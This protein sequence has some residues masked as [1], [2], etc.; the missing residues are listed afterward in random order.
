MNE[1]GMDWFLRLHVAAENAFEQKGLQ[2]KY[3]DDNNSKSQEVKL[4]KNRMVCV[5]SND[6]TSWDAVFC[7]HLVANTKVL[8][9]SVYKYFGQHLNRTDHSHFKRSMI[10]LLYPRKYET[11][12][13][14]SMQ[15]SAV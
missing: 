15:I 8:R 13:A 7:N 1:T 2:R 3:C 6:L 14:E 9:D 11:P 4:T 10:T 5:G 12:I